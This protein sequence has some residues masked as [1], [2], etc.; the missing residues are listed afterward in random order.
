M[1]KVLLAFLFLT[2]IGLLIVKGMV[3]NSEE[4]FHKQELSLYVAADSANMVRATSVGLGKHERHRVIGGR[5]YRN[6]VQLLKTNGTLDEQDSFAVV[7]ATG[8]DLEFYRDTILLGKFRM[9]DRIGR[10]SAMGVWK[11][12][13]MAKVNKFLKDQA[14]Q[15]MACKSESS[16]DETADGVL[17]SETNQRPILTMPK[18]GASKA[19]KNAERE[20]T[21]DSVADAAAELS[22]LDSAMIGESQNAL[23]ILDE[24]IL[25]SDTAVGEPLSTRFNRMNSGSVFFYNEDGS[26]RKDDFVALTKTQMEQ[27]GNLLKRTRLETF[28]MNQNDERKKYS[29]IT[30]F[31]ENNEVVRLWTLSE[32]PN[33][34]VK[35]HKGDRF[36]SFEGYWVPE[37]PAVLQAFFSSLK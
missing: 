23:K 27:L 3:Q 26:E 21:R 10:D 8:L 28:S 34:L 35:Y 13:H 33:Y 11:T 2:V 22:K 9:T 5:L 30:L 6:F 1:M 20:Q 29:Q 4:T 12:R 14:V 24:L 17:P 31:G 37:D 15:F 19:R 32:K 36:S 25:P 7:C 16:D 18:F